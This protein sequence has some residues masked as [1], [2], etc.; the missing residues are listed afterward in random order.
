MYSYNSKEDKT[1]SILRTLLGSFLVEEKPIKINEKV[2]GY[3]F[4][5]YYSN[6]II[7]KY[8]ATSQEQYNT[9][10]NIIKQSIGHYDIKE[11][12]DIKVYE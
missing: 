10:V 2:V 7:M 4:I 3:P 11:F 5:L 1:Y 12:Y 9:C 6:E 8:Y